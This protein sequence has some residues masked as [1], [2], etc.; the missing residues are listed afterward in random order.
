[1]FWCKNWLEL[2]QFSYNLPFPQIFWRPLYTCIKNFLDQKSLFFKKDLCFLWKAKLQRGADWEIGREGRPR[3]HLSSIC[4]PKIH[5]TILGQFETRSHV[6]HL[7]L[8]ID[9]FPGSWSGNWTTSRTVGTWTSTQMA[10]WHC[11]Q[12]Q[13]NVLHHNA[14]SNIS[15]NSILYL[16][17]FVQG[18]YRH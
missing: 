5:K 18:S 16:W 2:V 1:M 6:L 8:S 10:C 3:D 4:S 7:G 17:N 15:F 12:Q 14:D 11:R 9:A 13:L